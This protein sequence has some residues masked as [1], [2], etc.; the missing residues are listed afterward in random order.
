MA[1][2]LQ[3]GWTPDWRGRPGQG[4]GWLRTCD[5]EARM[6]RAKR[7]IDEECREARQSKL[8]TMLLWLEQCRVALKLAIR[9]AEA[10]RVLQS[11]ESKLIL[12]A[13]EALGVPGD[14]VSELVGRTVQETS[15]L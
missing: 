11:S 2:V 8:R 10:D 5:L 12:Q 14:V 13:A 9:I 4:H 3:Q 15:W 7:R 1:F 6:E